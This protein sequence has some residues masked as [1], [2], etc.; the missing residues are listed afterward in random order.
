MTD[1]WA[2]AEFAGSFRKP[3]RKPSTTNKSPRTVL[4]QVIR[5]NINTQICCRNLF[6]LQRQ[7]EQIL[8]CVSGGVKQHNSMLLA[9]PGTSS[10]TRLAS[11][12]HASTSGSLLAGTVPN[13]N[14]WHRRSGLP[15]S[16]PHTSQPR[17]S[18][19]VKAGQ[20]TALACSA[21][22]AVQQYGY[23]CT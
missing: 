6:T 3:L 5:Q 14:Q 15:T 21:A 12:A 4:I 23:V 17:L 8:I 7:C 22:A 11:S 18:C 2:R 13:N 9:P 20:A 19:R 10:C 1:S 16:H